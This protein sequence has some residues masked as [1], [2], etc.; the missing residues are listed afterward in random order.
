[1]VYKDEEAEMCFCVRASKMR[2]IFHHFSLLEGLGLF[3]WRRVEGWWMCL[4]L[5]RHS[6][7]TS[8]R[9]VSAVSGVL[10]KLRPYGE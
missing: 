8:W 2:R 4:R 6:R 5:H 9:E 10:I 1:M 3:V 7:P